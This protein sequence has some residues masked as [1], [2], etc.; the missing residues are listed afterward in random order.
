MGDDPTLPTTD[1]E[2]LTAEDAADAAHVPIRTLERWVADRRLTAVRRER[3][4]VWYRESDVLAVEHQTRRAPRTRLLAALAAED[5][6]H[7]G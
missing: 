5:L 4:R 1:G 2:Y 6:R 7:A 3:G